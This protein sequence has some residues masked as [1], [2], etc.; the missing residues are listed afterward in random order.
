MINLLKPRGPK[1]DPVVLSELIL[2]LD[3]FCAR[4]SWTLLAWIFW[5]RQSNDGILAV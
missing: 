3:F 1:V 4:L 2:W 5:R